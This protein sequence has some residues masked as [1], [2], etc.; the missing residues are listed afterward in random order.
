MKIKIS[1]Q[2]NFT[3]VETVLDNESETFESD[4][5]ALEALFRY[6]SEQDYNAAA[7]K[8]VKPNFAPR[9]PSIRMAT[10]SQVRLLDQYGLI[11]E[12]EDVNEITF[13]EA[14]ARIKNNMN[15]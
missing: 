6:L 14:Y 7:K 15:N 8:P 3:N 11:Y 9:K 4:L 12:D 10:P 1:R 13:D 5:M 2:C